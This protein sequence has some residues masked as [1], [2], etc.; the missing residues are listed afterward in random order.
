MALQWYLYIVRCREGTLY[1]GIATDVARRF[2][3]HQDNSTKAAKYLRG[4]GPLELV[5]EKAVGTNKRVALS[6]EYQM[7]NL[8]KSRKEAVLI[9]ADIIDRMV[10]CAERRCRQNEVEGR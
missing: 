1:T 2:A 3:E 6:V 7:K 4:R 8:P 9:Q 5:C 10:T